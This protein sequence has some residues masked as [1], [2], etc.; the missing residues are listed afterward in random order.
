[1]R[2]GNAVVP[3]THLVAVSFIVTLVNNLYLIDKFSV[4]WSSVTNTESAQCQRCDSDQSD[5]LGALLYI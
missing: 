5:L 2:I 1:M 4:N 3:K